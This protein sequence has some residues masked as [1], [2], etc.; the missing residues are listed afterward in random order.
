MKV[1]PVASQIGNTQDE[2]N[3]KKLNTRYRD[4]ERVNFIGNDVYLVQLTDHAMAMYITEVDHTEI[5]LF[6]FD[7]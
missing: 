4:G 2:D 3:N 1:F 7:K 5:T 6:H